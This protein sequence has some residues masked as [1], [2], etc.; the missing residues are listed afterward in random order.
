MSQPN[1]ADRLNEYIQSEMTHVGDNFRSNV[2]TANMDFI[3]YVTRHE[4][5]PE[6]INKY[7]LQRFKDC[8]PNN[9]VY[10]INIIKRFLKWCFN[11]GY[12][13]QRYHEFFPRVKVPP[14]GDVVIIGFE[15]YKTLL[16][17]C[18]DRRDKAWLITLGYSTGLRLKDCCLLCW[19]DINQE[20]MVITTKPN[21]TRNS[22]GRVVEI[23]YVAGS[24]LH[25]M[26]NELWEER[27]NWAYIG[28]DYVCSWAA[29][30]YLSRPRDLN[31]A[32]NQVFKY[33]GLI[34]KSFRHFRSTF[35]SLMANSGMNVGLAAK[36]TGR[37]DT[38]TILRYI[39][40]DMDSAR[41]GIAKALELHKS[42]PAFK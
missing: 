8:K 23:P 21:K 7:C 37:S 28:K 38:K 34:G 24:D 29:S 5:G 18:G 31:E 35:E 16:R 14:P 33:A 22:T 1:M 39:R 41:E 6:T 3:K 27:D 17:M 11:R 15:E 40:P 32:I 30:T 19:S 4:I 42:H 36:L 25:M 10:N 9:A 26:I 20:R 12:T 13:T 2:R